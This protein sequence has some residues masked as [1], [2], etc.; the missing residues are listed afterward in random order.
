MNRQRR[1][2]SVPDASVHTLLRR[3]L[4]NRVIDIS[5]A[6]S[7]IST[8]VYRVDAAT[9][10]VFFLRL[11]EEAGESRAAEARVHQ[12]LHRA[13]VPVPEVVVFEAR[14]PELDRSAMLTRR[15]PGQ[16]M[17]EHVRTRL[18]GTAIARAA[19]SAGRDLARINRIPV[20]GFGW[21]Q[22]VADDGTLMAEHP[23]RSAWTVEYR[24]AMTDIAGSGLLEPDVFDR[25]RPVMEHWLHL[26][27]RAE[28]QL[29]HGDLDASH[30]FLDDA[31][32]S[33]SGLIDF[34]E[35]RGADRLYDLGHALLQDA[36]PDRPPIF[37]PLLAGYRESSP[38][39][40]AETEI[41]DQAVAIGVRQLTIAHRRD[42]PATGWLATR[43]ESLLTT[44]ELA[45]PA[46]PGIER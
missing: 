18:D 28:S 7:G 32:L 17:V 21:V 45:A 38:F 42:S 5:R 15:I 4:P 34:G 1:P 25:L 29:A 43:L 8:P 26:P 40:A 24:R 23:S 12:M 6:G 30:I 16:A 44:P 41:R 2:T 10:E 35:I 39:A 27:D 3:W 36:Q 22:A 11:A 13:G 9:G 20:R 19:R 31:S 37:A 46:D 14:P 33:Y